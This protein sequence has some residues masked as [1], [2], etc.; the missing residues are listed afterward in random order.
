MG[1]VEWS[2]AVS[3]AVLLWSPGFGGL[4]VSVFSDPTLLTC[5]QKSFQ[6]TLPPG[7]E[8]NA[9]FVLTTWGETI[10]RGIFSHIFAQMQRSMEWEERNR[11]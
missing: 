11:F 4:N 10:L 3:G 1:V 7:S 2:W 9:S 6:V 8:G 5:G